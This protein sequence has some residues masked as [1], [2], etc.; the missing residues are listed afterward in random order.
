MSV[1]T[2][3]DYRKLTEQVMADKRHQKNIEFEYE[4]P[5]PGHPEGKIKYH[6]AEL[7]ANLERLK[8]PIAK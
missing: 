2:A 7:E 5:Q 8:A 4:R 3:R 6:I 1:E